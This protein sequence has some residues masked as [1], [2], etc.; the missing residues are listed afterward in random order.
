MSHS[1]VSHS[2]QESPGELHVLSPH[3]SFK[4]LQVLLGVIATLYLENA[5]EVPYTPL[6]D[7]GPIQVKPFNPDTGILTCGWLM[8]QI[9]GAPLL[10][11]IGF[12]PQALKPYVHFIRCSYPS[13]SSLV[14]PMP[15]GGCMRPCPAAWGSQCNKASINFQTRVKR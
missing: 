3:G 1:R 13:S 12:S 15:L 6:E 2:I 4:L 11:L 5:L 8:K 10:H 14:Q 9:L 7:L